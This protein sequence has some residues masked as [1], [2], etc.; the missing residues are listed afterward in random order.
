MGVWFTSD[1]HLGHRMVS[2]LRGFQEPA[3]HDDAVADGWV[4]RVRKDDQVWV[5]GDLAVSSP[6][7]ALARIATLPGE[8]HLITGN[9][10]GCFPAHRDAYRQQRKYLE[11]FSSVQSVAGRKVT[12]RA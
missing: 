8:K 6:A 2:R 4:S 1:L 5:L 12:G 9:H 10:D 7:A 11:V 3:E